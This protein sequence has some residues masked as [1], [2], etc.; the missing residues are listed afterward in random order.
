[1]NL[2]E[3]FAHG[4][5]AVITQWRSLP[6]MVPA[7]YPG[8]VPVHSPRQIAKA[9]MDLMTLESGESLR[10]IFLERFTLEKHLAALAEAISSIE[11]PRVSVAQAPSVATD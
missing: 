9:L 8:L 6:E 2:I 7:E 3:A 5:P 1:V 4:L 11:Q 10:E